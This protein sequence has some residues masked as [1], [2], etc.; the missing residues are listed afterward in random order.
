MRRLAKSPMRS[1]P[2][3]SIPCRYR[4]DNS[5]S[6]TFVLPDGCDLGYAQ[7]GSPTGRAVF[8]LHG[9]PGSRI[10]AVRLEQSALKHNARIIAVD[11]PGY[12][13]SSPQ[14][15]RTIL[16]HAKDIQDLAEHLELNEY[17][18]M[19]VSGGGPY[20]LACAASLP[21]EKL[22]AVAVVCGM[23]PPDMSKHGMRWWNWAGFTFG[24]LYFP[25]LT[26]WAFKSEAAGRLDLPDEKRLELMYEQFWNS[27]P[28]EKDVKVWEDIDF[29]R[30]SLRS[31]REAFDQG[32]EGFLLDGKLMALDF[33]FRIEDIRKDLPVRL[34][35]GLLDVN[36][37]VAHGNETAA[38]LSDGRVHLRVED[39]TH[40]SVYVNNL[41]RILKD[42]LDSI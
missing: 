29:P 33:G 36:V 23:G 2:D 8:Y 6:A 32:F 7:Y 40:T 10:E 26:R 34:W 39:D 3:T 18:V 4:M 11:R 1:L 42:L 13:W 17:A 5:T 20:V 14:P 22:R 19:G 31:A 16:D 9:L 38:R 30:L 12:G 28:H 27:N 21:A 15:R 24:Y 35:Y 41:E 37:P 25:W